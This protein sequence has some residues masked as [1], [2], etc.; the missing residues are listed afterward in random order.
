MAQYFRQAIILKALGS[1]PTKLHKMVGANLYGYKKEMRT[2]PSGFQAFTTQYSV[3][4]DP[5]HGTTDLTSHYS[6]KA[7]DRGTNPALQA[8][9]CIPRHIER[10]FV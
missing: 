4:I 7:F 6:V 2:E 9:P 8:F 1:G 5:I 3:Q 10:H